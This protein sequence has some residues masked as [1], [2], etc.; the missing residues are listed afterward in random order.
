MVPYTQIGGGPHKHKLGGVP[1]NTHW[2][3]SLRGVVDTRTLYTPMQTYVG[4]GSP[5]THIY[6]GVPIYSHLGGPH[7]HTYI[8]G[9]P[10]I[11]TLG[12]GPLGGLWTHTLPLYTPIQTYVG[13]GSPC[14]DIGGGSP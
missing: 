2:G 5:H 8:G 14:T 4:G 6:G 12:G 13:G 11:P 3:G 1:I 9:G 7:I 10:H